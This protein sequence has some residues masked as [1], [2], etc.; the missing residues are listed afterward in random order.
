MR[1]LI[2]GGTGQ[3]GIALT[4]EC[5]QHSDDVL[6]AGSADLDVANREQVFQVMGAWRPEVVIH[7]GA[8]T[9]V[10]GAE[11]DPI[12]AMRINAW[13]CRSI[14][15]AADLVGARVVAVSTDYVFDGKGS[16]PHGGGAYHEWDTPNPINMY[17]KSKYAGEREV[18]DCLG[19]RGCVV[20]T[21]WV[22]GPDGKN[23]LKTM[24]RVADQ[25]VENGSP[26]TVVND[27]HGSPTFTDDLARVLREL[28]IRR[29]G[30]VF[31]AANRGPTTWYDFARAI[32]RDS[33]H[34]ANRVQPVLSTD[35][36]PQRPAPRPAYSLLDSVALDALGLAPMD[37]WEVALTRN[38]QALERFAPR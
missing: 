25:G 8:W 35:L 19:Q 37:H 20:R 16:G 17:G 30:G 31:H 29:V 34:D 38:L 13:G 14:A 5:A 28:A 27:Q 32:F 1:V 22:C 11:A 7:A 26:V 10:D 21:A 3:L 33:G 12:R 24:L 23:F 6:A 15:E 36:Q 4:R 2:T 18:L 9:D